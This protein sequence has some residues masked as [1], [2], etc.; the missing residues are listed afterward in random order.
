MQL[1]TKRK[2]NWD[3][4]NKKWKNIKIY[5]LLLKYLN[6]DILNL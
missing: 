1:D 4:I 6:K 3:V 5:L 2:E